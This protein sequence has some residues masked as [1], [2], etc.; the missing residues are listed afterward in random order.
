MSKAIVF[1]RGDVVLEL[2]YEA[3]PTLIDYKRLPPAHNRGVPAFEWAARNQELDVSRP[4]FGSEAVCS[5]DYML[6]I[7]TPKGRSLVVGDACL[8]SPK[9]H[10]RGEKAKPYIVERYRRTLGW[11]IDGQIV[12]CHPMG[13]FVVYPPP[14]TAWT[15]FERLPGASDCTLLCPS[16]QGD[17]QASHRLTNLLIGVAPEIIDQ[18]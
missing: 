18:N 10:G 12:R 3:E 4:F 1:K 17:S 7:T 11:A 8:A 2:D 16:P 13:G 14:A 9:H 5:P 6:G 15:N